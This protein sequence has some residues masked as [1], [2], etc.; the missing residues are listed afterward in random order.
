MRRIEVNY[1]LVNFEDFDLVH[2]NEN[3][4]YK[5]SFDKLPGDIW[6]TYSAFANT[7]GGLIILGVS[8]D[9]GNYEEV[10]VSNASKIIQDFWNTINNR[11]KISKNILDNRHIEQKILDNGRSIIYIKVPEAHISDK[12]IFLNNN[13][14]KTYIRLYEG[15]RI[16]TDEQ[17]STFFRDKN[18]NQDSVLLDNYTIEDLSSET[19]QK[20]RQYISNK[21]DRY[22]N[23][24]DEELLTSIGVRCIDRNDER[25]YKLTEA[26]LLFFGKRRSYKK[27]FS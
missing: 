2:E 21:N 12:P 27:S 15:D 19:I 16:A 13:P 10:G 4:E 23:M 25:K 9:N 20:Y 8:E 26:A 22:T 11:E 24:S 17:I 14:N 18:S 1:K 6:P 7:K 3:I 5:E